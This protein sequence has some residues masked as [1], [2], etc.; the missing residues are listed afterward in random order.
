MQLTVSFFTL[1]VFLFR[2]FLLNEKLTKSMHK[3]DSC[4]TR[5]KKNTTRKKAK[6]KLKKEKKKKYKHIHI[7]SYTLKSYVNKTMTSLDDGVN[8]MV[9]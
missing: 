5:W 3:T 2:V 6:S 1:I 7:H 4:D 8:E 9:R